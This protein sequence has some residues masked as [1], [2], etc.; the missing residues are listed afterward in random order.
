MFCGWLHQTIPGNLYFALAIEAETP[1][2]AACVV[3]GVEAE[4]AAV[5]RC[6]AMDGNAQ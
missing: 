5:V 3:A 1:K 4:S 2:C 6:C